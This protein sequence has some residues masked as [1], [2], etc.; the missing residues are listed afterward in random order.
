MEGPEKT[1]SVTELVHFLADV[2]SKNG[3]LLLNI[4]PMAD[5]TIPPI[6]LE[7]LKGLGRWL[8][9]NG[10]A[11]YATRP[12]EVAE[13]VAEG[14]VQVR[15]TARGETVYAIMLGE[16]SGPTLL[17]DLNL[18]EGSVVKLLGHTEPLA[19]AN[20]ESGVRI[21]LPAQSPNTPAMAL[22]ISPRPRLAHY[23]RS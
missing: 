20:T 22:S 16:R 1:L 8:A 12:W 13:G 6:Q 11:I 15:Y 18:I 23:A 7:R 10:D 2:V 4:G 21:E 14:G 5:G 17:T 3:N 19:W 9:I